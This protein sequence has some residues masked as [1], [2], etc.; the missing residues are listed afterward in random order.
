MSIGVTQEDVNKLLKKKLMWSE[1]TELVG[2]VND[3]AWFYLNDIESTTPSKKRFYSFCMK[4]Y[5]Q[6]LY[7][8]RIPYHYDALG[9]IY[10]DRSEIEDRLYPK[11]AENLLFEARKIDSELGEIDESVVM[12]ERSETK[13]EESKIQSLKKQEKEIIQQLETL[14]FETYYW[15]DWCLSFKDDDHGHFL[16]KKQ[17][18]LE[19]SDIFFRMGKYKCQ[20]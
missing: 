3:H 2:Q 13:E 20:K 5:L 4:R 7:L 8:L 1:I 11:I 16:F 10:V 17:E 9:K 14:G 15:N 19:E 18:E 6:E 12:E